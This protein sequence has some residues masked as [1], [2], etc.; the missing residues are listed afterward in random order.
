MRACAS[1]VLQQ[2]AL[3]SV[4]QRHVNSARFRSSQMRAVYA[5]RR[6]KR[7]EKK[8]YG[9]AQQKKKKRG[10]CN[11]TNKK[12][13]TNRGLLDALGSHVVRGLAL[14]LKQRR[15]QVPLAE[16]RNDAN[17]VLACKL[18]PFR[19]FHRGA[20]RCARANA[21][22]QPFLCRQPARKL[23]RLSRAHL[24]HF[25]VHVRVQNRRHKPRANALDLMRTGLTA[26]QHGAF[27]RLH[28]HNVRRWILF[29]QV[30]PGARDRAAGAHARHK[31]LALDRGRDFRARRFVV[32]LWVVRV[33][34]LLQH[35]R[36]VRLRHDFLGHRNGALHSLRGRR[37]HHLCA[38][39]EQDHPPLNRH[40]VRHR[41]NQLV[42]ARR[43]N[44]RERNPCV[45][46]RRFH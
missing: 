4:L 43:R 22:Q 36:I 12:T 41:Q 33:C 7:K 17:H 40:R 13:T 27:R 44:K 18:G 46:R 10:D 14:R 37:E 25:I 39:R 19:D 38:E 2:R 23:N 16:R 32:R 26:R 8:N 3:R 5:A 9:G 34:K 28:R 11:K 6:K 21:A 1:V 45:P 31:H 29:L 42:P 24:Q 15:R 30:P 20:D 35:V